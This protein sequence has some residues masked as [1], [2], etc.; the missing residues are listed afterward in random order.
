M[1]GGEGRDGK[2]EGGSVEAEGHVVVFKLEDSDCYVTVGTFAR[3]G[4]GS[5]KQRH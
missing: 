4:L 2:Q 5:A 3:C 1:G